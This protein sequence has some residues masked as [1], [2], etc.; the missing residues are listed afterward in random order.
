MKVAMLPP[1]HF[2]RVL[3][4]PQE[5]REMGGPGLAPISSPPMK[6]LP[7]FDRASIFLPQ[8]N[9]L[10]GREELGGEE[11][12]VDERARCIISQTQR[13]Q[14]AGAARTRAR[15]SDSNP[16]LAAT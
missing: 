15:N 6:S 4:L 9:Q 2:D 8:E 11:E 14:L 16:E 3:H 10:A 12:E 1:L 7:P 5:R 13:F